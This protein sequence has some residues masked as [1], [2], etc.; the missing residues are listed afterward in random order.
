[1]ERKPLPD[2]CVVGAPATLLTYGNP[3]SATRVTI[4]RVNKVSV[5][6]TDSQGVARLMSVTRGLQHSTG[7]WGQLTELVPDDNPLAVVAFARQ[8]RVNTARIVQDALADWARTG[9]DASLQV[10][11][12]RL[13]P[14]AAADADGSTR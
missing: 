9:D 12:T 5:T 1:M 4:S 13:A 3:A 10:A 6:V 8:R 7:T 11:I 14:Y 2:W